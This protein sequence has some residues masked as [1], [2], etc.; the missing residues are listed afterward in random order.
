[1]LTLHAQV[2]DLSLPGDHYEVGSTQVLGL[3]RSAPL[4]L[5]REILT[6][7]LAEEKGYRNG[8][9]LLADGYEFSPEG[10]AWFP[11]YDGEDNAG[12]C[13]DWNR[14]EP[15]VPEYVPSA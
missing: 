10:P 2:T 12:W 13:W 14:E 1:M 7:A 8:A 6:Y 11:G 3:P 5:V 4:S 15:H 9:V